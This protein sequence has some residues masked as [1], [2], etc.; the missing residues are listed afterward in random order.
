MIMIEFGLLLNKLGLMGTVF[1][2]FWYHIGY[3]IAMV[4]DPN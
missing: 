2:G 1:C 4:M 3:W